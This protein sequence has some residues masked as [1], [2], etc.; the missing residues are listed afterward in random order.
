M[1][2]LKVPNTYP[3]ISFCNICV[4][5]EL[6]KL[7]KIKVPPKVEVKDKVLA[8]RQ[9]LKAALKVKHKFSKG[10]FSHSFP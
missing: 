8:Q 3:V 5:F 9:A 10:Q 4:A 6:E 2:N 1:T 7:R